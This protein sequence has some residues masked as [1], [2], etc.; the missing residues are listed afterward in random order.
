[1]ADARAVWEPLYGHALSDGDVIEI[2]TNVRR[3]MDVL[4]P[5]APASNKESS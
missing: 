2:L 4:R 3:L 5:S 1:M